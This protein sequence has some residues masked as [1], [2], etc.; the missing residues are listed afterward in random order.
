MPWI[1]CSQTQLDRPQREQ[2]Q[3][4]RGRQSAGAFE[5]CP[6]AERGRRCCLGSTTTTMRILQ[7]PRRW[8]AERALARFPRKLPC[9]HRFHRSH[10]HRRPRRRQTSTPLGPGSRVRPRPPPRRRTCTRPTPV[11]RLWIAPTERA[12]SRPPPRRRRRWKQPM[13]QRSQWSQWSQ[14]SQWWWWWR[15]RQRRRQWWRRRWRW[16]RRQ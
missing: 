14:Q 2:W 1:S 12:A 7:R 5:Q 10:R 15:R 16:R 8:T 9:S 13:R 6:R 3:R 11:P 4:R